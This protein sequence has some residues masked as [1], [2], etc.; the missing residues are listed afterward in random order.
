MKIIAEFYEGRPVAVDL[1]S[2]STFEVVET[3]PV[4]R[5]ATKP[6]STKPATLSN[7]V[8]IN[9]PE[10]VATGERVRVNPNTGEYLDRAKD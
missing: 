7:G 9:V 4:M 2:T 10:F 1:P 5:G 3:S 8:T 6:A